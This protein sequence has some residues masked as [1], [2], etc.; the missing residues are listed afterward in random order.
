[1]AIFTDLQDNNTKISTASNFNEL[2]NQYYFTFVH[3]ISGL[4]NEKSLSIID[5]ARVFKDSSTDAFVKNILGNAD[6]KILFLDYTFH[7]INSM[8]KTK[9]ND[10]LLINN[11]LPLYADENIYFVF[12]GGNVMNYFMESYINKIENIFK[13][14][15]L[16]NVSYKY[17]NDN[18]LAYTDDNNMTSTSTYSSFFSKLKE[19]FKISDVDYSIYIKASNYARYIL[20]HG[21]TIKI[22]GQVLSTISNNFDMLFTNIGKKSLPDDYPDTNDNVDDID[23]YE[24]NY[25]ELKKLI[26]DEKFEKY[27]NQIKNDT[28]H[29][30]NSDFD[31]VFFKKMT[32]SLVSAS[33]FVD[34]MHNSINSITRFTKIYQLITI[35]QYLQTIKFL[36]IEDNDT[37]INSLNVTQIQ[38]HFDTHLNNLIKK[39]FNNIQRSNFYSEENL[40]NIKLDTI[41]KLSEL[42]NKI[43][44]DENNNGLETNIKKYELVNI[45]QASDIVFGKRKDLIIKSNNNPV[46]Q[47]IT[48]ESM[49][50]HLHYITYNSII[51]SV[52]KVNISNFNLMRIKINIVLTGNNMKINDNYNNIPIPSEFVD[53]SI[54]FYDDSSS[55]KYIESLKKNDPTKIFLKNNTTNKDIVIQSYGLNDLTHDLLNVLFQQNF[56]IPWLDLKYNKRIFRLLF[57]SILNSYV[58]DCTFECEANSM[59]IYK[60]VLD[61]SYTILKYMLDITSNQNPSYPYS[62]CIKFIDSTN[63]SF[64]HIK[65]EIDDITIKYKKSVFIDLIN[66]REVYH[67]LA[68]LLNFLIVYSRYVTFD[69]DTAFDFMNKNRHDYLYVPLEKNTFSEYLKSSNDKFIDMLKIIVNDGYKIYFIF[70]NLLNMRRI[71]GHNNQNGGYERQ[72]INSNPSYIKYL[73]YKKKYLELKRSIIY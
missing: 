24:D 51:K 33:K 19:N 30:K 73:K 18:I 49:D 55:N 37:N 34:Q 42:Q 71:Y 63:N 65:S 47:Y 54:P 38:I 12:K 68:D 22:L 7:F 72:K 53:V 2:I 60:E 40:E 17:Q 29:S 50:T 41:K 70:E 32:E 11:Q 27:F 57:I 59:T 69:Y 26:V 8:V 48:S 25:N 66:I 16:K 6:T 4:I 13:D 62:E 28:V 39:K 56:F 43:K 5:N 64:D 9:I 14:I 31:A 21:G 15:P 20:I 10:Y 3:Q 44:Y 35:I 23:M 46:N 45:P 52:K 1:M 58:N 67:E 61:F 36:K